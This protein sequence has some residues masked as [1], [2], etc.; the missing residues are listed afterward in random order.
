MKLYFLGL[1]YPQLMH[2][3][4]TCKNWELKAESWFRPIWKNYSINLLAFQFLFSVFTMFHL[5][6]INHTAYRDGIS[7][8]YIGCGVWTL[9]CWRVRCIGPCLGWKN[10]GSQVPPG[11][12]KRLKFQTSVKYK[13]DQDSSQDYNS[14]SNILFYFFE[15]ENELWSSNVCSW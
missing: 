3:F 7:H 6:S 8:V 14:S 2:F 15:N 1:L 5:S 11:M 10:E 4:G 12:F 9:V 13:F